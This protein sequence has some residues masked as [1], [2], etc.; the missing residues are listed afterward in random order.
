MLVRQT[1]FGARILA[2]A[3]ATVASGALITPES[4]AAPVVMCRHHHRVRLRVNRCPRGWRVI[5]PTEL[6]VAGPVGPPGAEGPAGPRESAG[7]EGPS[8]APGAE[9]PTGPLG[10]SGPEGPTGSTGATGSLGS[11]GPAGPSGAPGPVGAAGPTGA[12]GLTGATGPPGPAT[13][14]AGGALTGTY[15]APS[16]AANAI[17]GVSLFAA[18]TVPAARTLVGSDRELDT[19]LP[20]GTITLTWTGTDFDTDGLFD[21]GTPAVLT[22]QHAGI[23]QVDAG[24]SFDQFGLTTAIQIRILQNG[25]LRASNQTRE[26]FVG[27]ATVST[28]TLVQLAPGDTLSVELETD[29]LGLVTLLSEGT[30]LATHWAGPP[31]VA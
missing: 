10:P 26:F 21:P 2:W 31:P 11:T 24:A 6:G 1:R 23:Y 16:L 27:H 29:F 14:P 9:G 25:V 8:G 7:S 12:Q 22:A 19:A 5:S 4:G 17:D 15:P 3:M 30:F 18:G 28:S 13:G 20:N